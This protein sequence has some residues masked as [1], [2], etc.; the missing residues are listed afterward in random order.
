QFGIDVNN[1]QVTA[2]HIYEFGSKRNRRIEEA[3]LSATIQKRL[4]NLKGIETT[5]SYALKY[6]R[7]AQLTILI[8]AAKEAISTFEKVIG[9]LAVRSGLTPEERVSLLTLRLA[10]NDYKARLN[11]FENE[12]TLLGGELT[13]ITGCEIINPH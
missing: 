1:L 12:K 5:V 9:K 13:F 11:D 8:D 7:V 2:Q 3:Q 10:A 4:L 6:Q